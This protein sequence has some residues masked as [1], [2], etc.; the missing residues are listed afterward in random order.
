MRSV[1]ECRDNIWKLRG[2]SIVTLVGFVSRFLSDSGS[3][4]VRVRVR[5]SCP[6]S[7]PVRVWVRVRVRIW[8][9]FGFVSK[10]WNCSIIRGG[11]TY[12]QAMHLWLL[13]DHS[14]KLLQSEPE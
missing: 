10:I 12:G 9:V 6:G 4:P 8:L 2:R 13:S 1:L 5:G 14:Y 3:G 7:C 11:L